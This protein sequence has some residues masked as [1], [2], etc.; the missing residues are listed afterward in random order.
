MKRRDF[1]KS[2]GAFIVAARLLPACGDNGDKQVQPD[3]G[4]QQ[5]V[6]VFPQGVAS[7]DPRP[8]SVVL[9][10]RAVA[11]ADDMAVV[12]V[13]L[14]V[15]SDGDFAT[16]VVDMQLTAAL[17]SDHTVRVL[18]TS[19]S[20]NTTYYYRFTAGADQAVGRTRTAPAATDDVQVNLAWVSCQDYQ[21]G[22]Y[23]AYAQMLV[24]DMARAEADQIHFV[25]HVGDAIYETIDDPSQRA[26]DANFEYLTLKN[27]DGSDRIP[28]PFPSGG[29]TNKAGAKF[30]RTVDDYRHLYKTV[31]ADVNI[32]AARARWPFIYTWDDHEFSNDYWQSQANYIDGVSTDEPS[33]TRKY[34]ANHAWFEYIPAH[35]SGAPGVEGVTQNAKDF[36]PATVTDAPFTTP[37]ATNFVDE[38]NNAAAVGSMTIYRSLRWGKHVELVMTDER[39]YRSDHAIPEE[40]VAT[41]NTAAG[42]AVF[43]DPRNFLPLPLV[44]AMDAGTFANMSMFPLNDQGATIDNPRKDSPPGTMLGKAQ[45][46]W[47]KDTMSGSDATWKLWGNE[48]PLMRMRVTNPGNQLGFERVLDGDAWDGY[49]LERNTLMGYLA[50]NQIGNVVAL[51]GDIHAHF[52]G[53][54]MHNFDAPV[55]QRIPVMAEL[56][57]AGISSNSLFSFYEAATRNL[58]AALRGLVT[59]DASAGG[60][61]AFTENINLLITSGTAAAATYAATKSVATANTQADPDA[62]PHIKYVDTNAQGYGYAKV[63]D[64]QIEAQLVTINR[65]IGDATGAPG[66]LRTASFV[67]PSGNPAGMTTTV[68]GTK[69][70]PLS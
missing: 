18:V 2:A 4:V 52:G 45:R 19:L 58:P 50:T 56:V 12:P 41:L 43:F 49:N 23:G 48:V 54:V 32:Q 11:A 65:P 42:Q 66:V 47:W 14:E 24:D 16:P 3:G 20:A 70:F 17:E 22:Q 39:S 31:F 37:D 34:N 59:V 1:L 53:I 21:S 15:A 46:D 69:P 51:T 44:L 28:L 33:Q 61:S 35:L 60:G 36:T 62:N 8:N 67:I 10:T 6:Y 5:G 9:W 63:T 55:D 27:A 64:T 30:A 26:L 40:F 13:R 68:T 57:T 7:G 29:G 38:P 25:M